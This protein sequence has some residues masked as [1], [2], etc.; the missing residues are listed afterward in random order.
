MRVAHTDVSETALTLAKLCPASSVMRSDGSSASLYLLVIHLRTAQVSSASSK[1]DVAF[2]TFGCSRAGNL[3]ELHC[4]F[5]CS[6]D[7][8]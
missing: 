8:S 3:E 7:T 1:L 6:E 5:A 2:T 4:V